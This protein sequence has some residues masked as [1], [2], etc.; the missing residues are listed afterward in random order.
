MLNWRLE[1]ISVTWRA[2]SEGQPVGESLLPEFVGEF[3]DKDW[4]RE[5]AKPIVVL[6]VGLSSERLE[7][8]RT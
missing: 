7:R 5:R 3:R 1:T 2:G 4:L 6:V 8:R